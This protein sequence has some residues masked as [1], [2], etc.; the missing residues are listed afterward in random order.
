MK[1]YKR[2]TLSLALLVAS[3]IPATVTAQSREYI[4]EAISE[5]GEC[6]NVAIT[7]TG[8]DLMIYGKNGVYQYGCPAS[9][10]AE[11]EELNEE[12]HYIDDVQITENGR[13]IILYDDNGVVWNNIPKSLERKIRAWNEEGERIDAITLNDDGDWVIVGQ[14]KYSASSQDFMDWLE[15]G[16][17]NHGELW[18][19]CMTDDAMVAVYSRGYQFIGD[20]PYSLKE[21]LSNT[22]LDVYRLKIAGTSWFFANKSGQYQYKM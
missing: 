16:E 1:H 18:T 11:L 14:T 5:I 2:I 7:R 13:W 19:V 6:R 3:L 8:G 22:T 4:R 17:R 10:V 21:A 20:V 15:E 12:N 9:L